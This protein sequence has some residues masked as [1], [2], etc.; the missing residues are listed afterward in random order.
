M[1][2]TAFEP[3]TLSQLQQTSESGRFQG[4]A[5]GSRSE[6][7]VFRFVPDIT[8]NAGGRGWYLPKHPLKAYSAY[9]FSQVVRMQRALHHTRPNAAHEPFVIDWNA[10]KTTNLF[11]I[12]SRSSFFSI[13]NVPF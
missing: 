4:S 9:H 7:L 3:Q 5:V 2:L 8:R 10:G 11:G 12:Q 6:E 13:R 1:N